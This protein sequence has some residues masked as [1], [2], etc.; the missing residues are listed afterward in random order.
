MQIYFLAKMKNTFDSLMC[1]PSPFPR[2]TILWSASSLKTCPARELVNYSMWACDIHNRTL[3]LEIVSLQRIRT[4]Q[5]PYH[6]RL[7]TGS[8]LKK[9]NRLH[10]EG[11]N[12][13]WAWKLNISNIAANLIRGLHTYDSHICPSMKKTEVCDTVP[14]KITLCCACLLAVH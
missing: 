13:N 4:T 3:G 5:G 2:N 7:I 9:T 8:S 11:D 1:P 6:P 12:A 10:S 14:F